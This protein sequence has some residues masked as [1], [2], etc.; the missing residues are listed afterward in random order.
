[1]QRRSLAI[2]NVAQMLIERTARPVT[3]PMVAEATR[4]ARL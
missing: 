4:P 2:P 3:A 1:M